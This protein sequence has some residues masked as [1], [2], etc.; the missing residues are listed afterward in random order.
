MRRDT[1]YSPEYDVAFSFAGE[2]RKYVEEAASEALHLG[3]H[4][5]YDRYEQSE[6]WGANLFTRL[7]EV[8]RRQARYCV[9]FISSHYKRKLWASHEL[10]SAQARA[11]EQGMEYILPA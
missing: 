2:D 8:Y 11:L 3:V 10:R 6:L 1:S 4:V 5:F 7:D 9:V